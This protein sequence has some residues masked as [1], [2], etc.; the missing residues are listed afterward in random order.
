MPCEPFVLPRTATSRGSTATATAKVVGRPLG[1]VLRRGPPANVVRGASGAFL[2]AYQTHRVYD[3]FGT[4]NVFRA[5]VVEGL[6]AGFGIGTY[7][8]LGNTVA[9]DNLAPGAMK[10]LVGHNSRTSTCNG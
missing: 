4:G 7:P 1:R 10:G 6:I 3:G 5:N 2:N 9:C 8:Q